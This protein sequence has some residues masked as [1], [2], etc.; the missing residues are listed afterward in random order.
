MRL[1][2][3]PDGYMT[4]RK[5]EA[6][7]GWCENRC[8]CGLRADDEMLIEAAA[9][10]NALLKMQPYLDA[11]WINPIQTLGAFSES[12]NKHIEKFK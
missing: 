7:L 3:C 5:A 2:Q 1:H 6:G 4:C 12:L 10:I 11:F 8:G 9:A